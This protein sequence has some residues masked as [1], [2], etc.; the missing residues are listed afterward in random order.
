MGAKTKLVT[1]SIKDNEVKED[2]F[3]ADA[4]TTA[5][6]AADSVESSEI[7]D[8]TVTA[9][10]L[11]ST[12]DLS[13]N[14]VTLPNDNI[15]ADKIADNAV[16][17]EHLDVT[18]VTGHT[19]LDEQANDADV[20]LVFDTSA[21]AL[22]KVTKA[23]IAPASPVISALSPTNANESSAT[24]TL[25]IAGTG[26]TVGSNARLITTGGRVQA[27]D[28][29]TRNSATQL[30]ATIPTSSLSASDDPYDVQVIN[31]EGLATTSENQI[32][33]NA[34]PTFTTSAGSLGSARFSMAGVEVNAV[35]PDSAGNVTFEKQSGALPPGISLTN[36]SANGGTATF[37]GTITAQASDTTF[38][39]VLR[40]VDAASNTTSRA[41]SFTAL[42]PQTTSFTSSG[43]FAVPTG[44]TSV[45]VLVVAGGGGVGSNPGP[46]GLG[47]GGA[48][49]LIFH[50]LF[51]KDEFQ[52]L[53][54]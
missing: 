27:F 28:T 11:A 13:S 30:T 5:K 18:A 52:C 7:N 40:A 41:F 19:L 1:T 29:V 32:N 42:G 2:N 17:E 23:N 34:S 16:S 35:D 47:G 54:L 14:T 50:Q 45:D 48:G 31:G 8:G 26:F 6:L 9:D 38:N 24:F 36:T 12:L 44:Q 20:L 51:L 33:F 49:G 4:I 22:K 46:G 21:S 37:T 53:H 25:T 15:N 10:D 43:T 39:F 3:D